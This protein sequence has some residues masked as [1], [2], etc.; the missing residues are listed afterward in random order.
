MPIAY[1]KYKLVEGF[2]HNWL[3]AG[4]EIKPVEFH[5]Q[6]TFSSDE[7]LATLR[8]TILTTLK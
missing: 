7:K 1:L 6:F 8:K 3:T 4:P 2:I 5:E